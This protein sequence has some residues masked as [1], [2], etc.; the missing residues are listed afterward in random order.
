[1]F[2]RERRK[3]EANR[4]FADSGVMMAG[5]SADAKERRRERDR[6]ARERLADWYVRQLVVATW[7]D[8]PELAPEFLDIKRLIVLDGRKRRTRT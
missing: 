8:W 5:T 7:T 3:A 6:G 4:D 1:M 2:D